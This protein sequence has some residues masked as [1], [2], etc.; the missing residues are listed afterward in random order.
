MLLTRI[1]RRTRRVGAAT[2]TGT[3][4]LGGLFLAA[5]Q[6]DAATAF[7]STAVNTGNS[8]CATVPGSTAGQQL[9]QSGC[10]SAANQSFSF[11]PVAGTADQY[12]VG[13]STAGSC[14]DVSGAGTADNAQV[15]QWTCHSNANQ[16]FQL[17]AAGAGPNTFNLV[18]V[19]SGKCVAPA[20][21]AAA[22]GTALV[23]ITCS[24][25][26]ARVW[27]LPG[28]SNTTPT[29]PPTG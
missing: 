15:I 29:T 7:T 5:R 11:T 18:A 19:H 17:R 13:T 27:R 3:L 12:N 16:R 1:S 10:A 26:A 9:N 22:A 25:A 24:T 4:V 14:L 6:A 2:L 21:D 28:Y 23:Q 8:N 20:G